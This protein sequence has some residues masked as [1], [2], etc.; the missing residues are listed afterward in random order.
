MFGDMDPEA[1]VYL[2]MVLVLLALLIASS[3]VTGWSLSMAARERDKAT[4]ARE[5]AADAEAW[6]VSLADEIAHLQRRATVDAHFGQTMWSN[7][8]DTMIHNGKDVRKRGGQ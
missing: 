2:V 4:D 8:D 1:R 5:R 3:A 6:S 7:R